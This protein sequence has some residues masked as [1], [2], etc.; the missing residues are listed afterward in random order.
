MQTVVIADYD[1]AWPQTFETLRRRVA[2]ALG[3]MVLAIEHVGS[4]SVPNMPAKPI[5]DF[6]VVVREEHIPAAIAAIKALGYR[7]E[8]DLGV[9]GRE[10]FRW[11]AE[12]PEHHLYLCAEGSPALHRH[13]IVRDYLRAHPED[14]RA[15]AE[16]KRK[17]AALHHDNRTKYQ[18]AK[19]AFV[20]DLLR[21]AEEWRKKNAP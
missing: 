13:L 21:K 7:H 15:Y 2:A 6:D 1:P 20:D 10:A 19:A 12:F 14:A 5:I 16:H 17:L 8:G 18:E 9:H 11:T 4:T 3:S